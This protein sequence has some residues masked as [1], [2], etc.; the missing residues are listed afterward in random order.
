MPVT[1][2]MGMEMPSWYDI[3]SLD[4]VSGVKQINQTDL[5]SSSRRIH[6]HIEEEITLLGGEADKVFVGG[7]SQG[8]SLSLFSALQYK[9]NLG[10]ICACSACLFDSIHLEALPSHKKHIPILL[11]HGLMDPMVK[12]TYAV[13]TYR[14]LHH[15]KFNI[16]FEHED[17]L[18]HSFSLREL[19]IMKTYYHKYMNHQPQL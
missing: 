19:Q 5:E 16:Q 3:T 9:E 12:Y 2:N 6:K 17:N 4:P 18:G 13:D 1:I 15:F 7:F 8:G 10:G 11:Y 14:P